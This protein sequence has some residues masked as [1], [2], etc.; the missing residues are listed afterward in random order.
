MSPLFNRF[1]PLMGLFFAGLSF[2]LLSG[3]GN[4]KDEPLAIELPLLGS[5]QD[6]SYDYKGTQRNFKMRLLNKPLAMTKENL[7]DIEQLPDAYLIAKAF[8]VMALRG[9]ILD[10]KKISENTVDPQSHY[11]RLKK[12]LDKV[13]QGDL[14]AYA[15]KMIE[16]GQQT[17]LIGDI[18]LDADMLI[19]VSRYVNE[20]A[21]DLYRGIS[22]VKSQDGMLKVDQYAS[23]DSLFIRQLSADDFLM[24][25]SD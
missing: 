24:G 17:E 21:P 4:T 20:G 8:T 22:V 25:D 1:Y 15:N 16:I 14:Q 3:C 13:M 5:Y 9:G 11:A 12:I 7:S 6:V 2:A 23:Q 18:R 10:L 19:I